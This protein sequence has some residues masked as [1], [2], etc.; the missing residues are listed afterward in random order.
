[1]KSLKGVVSKIRVLKMSNPPLV[2]FSINGINCLI[3]AHSLNFLVDV[4]EGMQIVVA[5]EYNDR[6]QFVVKKYSV[7]GKT[8]IMMVFENLMAYN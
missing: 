5:G 7:I 3:A 8:K 6:E 2:R 4:D 1:M